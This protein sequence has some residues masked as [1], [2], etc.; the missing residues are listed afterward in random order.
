MSL[1]ATS[2]SWQ[3]GAALTV[4]AVTY[5][6][7]FSEVIHR[8][9]AAVIGAVVMVGI[10]TWGHFYSQEQALQAID[11]N[12]L[13]LLLAMMMIIVLLKPTGGFDYLAI[14]IAKWSGGSSVRLLIYLSLAVSLISTILDNVTTVLIFAPLTVLICRMV[15][16]NPMPFLMAE[17]IMSNIGGVA[18]LIGDPPNLMIGSKA[19]IDFTTFVVHMGPI[20]AVVWAICMVLLVA[21]FWNQLGEG[22]RFANLDLDERKAIKNPFHLQVILA[23][24]AIVITLFFIHH[25]FHLYPSYVALIGVALILPFVR[26]EPQQLFENLEWSVLVFFAG[27]F[28][29]VGG[30]E[31]TGFLNLIGV[32]FARIAQDPAMLLVTCLLLMWVAAILSAVVDN[33]PFTVTMIPIVQSLEAHGVNITPLWWALALGAGLGGNGTHI[34]AT[35]NII[36]LTEAERSGIPEARITPLAWIRAGVPIMIASLASASVIMVLFFPFF[37]N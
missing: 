3:M 34:G 25:H 7:I 26:P 16:L 32:Q 18:T 2:F 23:A 27:L 20:V 17:A 13:M 4:F 11:G 9:H 30:L 35:A 8:A 37:E 33:I 5:V 1:E 15:R 28:S 36:C 21:M 22:R 6:L 12:T 19:N 24:L 29:V 31:A 10:G 14:R